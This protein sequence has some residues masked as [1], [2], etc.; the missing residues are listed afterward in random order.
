MPLRDVKSFE[1]GR[2]AV[3]RVMWKKPT[4]LAVSLGSVACQ[5]LLWIVKADV[6]VDR[7]LIRI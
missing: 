3:P 6:D 5:Y 4:E 1:A 7:L 2:M